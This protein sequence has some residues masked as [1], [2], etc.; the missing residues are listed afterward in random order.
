MEAAL[1]PKREQRMKNL[2]DAKAVLGPLAPP[3]PEKVT[4]P[5]TEEE[6]RLNDFLPAQNSSSPTSTLKYVIYYKV[7]SR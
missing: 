7:D 2:R 4:R 3:A 5:E 1:L 6:G